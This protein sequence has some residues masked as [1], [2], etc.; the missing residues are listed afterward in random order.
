[1]TFKEIPVVIIQIICKKEAFPSHKSLNIIIK[2][3]KA[4]ENDN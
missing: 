3:I 1:M 4:Y 2:Q